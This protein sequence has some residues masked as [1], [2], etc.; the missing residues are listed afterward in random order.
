MTDKIQTGLR[1]P[2]ERYKEITEIAERA[3]ISVNALVLHLVDIGL[4]AVSLGTKKEH[5]VLLH[6]LRDIS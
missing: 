6:N 4:A 3:G 5:R 1:I 2:E